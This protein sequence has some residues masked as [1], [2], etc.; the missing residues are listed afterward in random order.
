MI[1]GYLN[2]KTKVDTGG[3]DK[4]TKQISKQASKLGGVFSGA[5]STA[6]GF[7]A[8]QVASMVVKSLANVANQAIELASDMDEVQNVVDTAFGSMAYKCEEFADVAIDQFGMSK[9]SAKQTASTYMSMAKSMGLSMDAASDMAIET[10]KLTGDIASFYNISTDL[11]STKLKSIFTGETET[12]KDLGVVMTEV[13]LKQYALANG[14]KTAY[15]DMSQAE[16]VALRYSFV[17]DALSDAQGDFAKTSDSWANQT[18]ILSERWKELLSIM[19][20]GL[21]RIFTPVIQ[22]INQIM[23]ALINLANAF[24]NTIGKLF[25][26]NEQVKASTTSATAAAGAESELAEETEEAGKAASGSL[27]SFDKLDVLQKSTASGTDSSGGG[28]VDLSF[29]EVETPKADTSVFDDISDSISRLQPYV[30]RLKNSWN[31]L[32]AAFERFANSKG[33]QAVLK[34]LKAILAF[35]GERIIAAGILILAGALDI[36]SGALDIIAGILTI[37]VGLFTGDMKTASDGLKQVFTGLGEVVKGLGKILE[38]VFVLILGTKAT[39]AI[40]NAA[41]A[42]KDWLVGGIQAFVPQMTALGSEIKRN[43]SAD[44]EE[45]KT[46]TVE[47]WN[48]ISGA[49]VNAATAAKDGLVAAW[50]AA[51]T[52]TSTAWNALKTL[53]TD[54]ITTIQGNIQS[55]VDGIANWFTQTDGYIE[56]IKGVFNGLLTFFKGVFTANWELAWKGVKTIFKNTWN[57]IINIVESAVNLIIRAVNWCIDQI[58]K[59]HVEVPSWVEELTGMSSFGFSIPNLSEVKLPRLASGAVIPPNGEFLAMLGDQRSGNNLEAPESLIRQIVREESGGGDVIINAKG[60]M[61]QL[62]RLLKLE[63]S[64]EDSRAGKSFAR[65][66]AY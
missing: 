14:Y 55:F 6:I 49:I 26:F 33:V 12:L 42:V 19:G 34:I 20:S 36:L 50:N 53:V 10:A 21:I 38:S 31:N 44:W 27:A 9:L 5:M 35:V 23:S 64:R 60:T 13:N 52:A 18:R 24:A 66:G 58:N 29:E 40:K 59:I 28:G 63:I 8:A 22:V 43:L 3:F 45:I 7:G 30:D 61:G 56:N 15:K 41:I 57:N 62:I 39:E 11:A 54:V 4:G 46:F 17:M 51:K 48:T 32:K 65:G 1:D 16:K 2:F 47:A 25:G 37:V